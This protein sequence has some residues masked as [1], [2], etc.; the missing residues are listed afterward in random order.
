[1][2]ILKLIVADIKDRSKIFRIAVDGTQDINSK[3]Q[4]SLCVRHVDSDLHVHKDSIRLYQQDDTLGQTIAGTN[5]EWVW[6]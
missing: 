6:T 4:L 5:D 3:E 2:S 1:M